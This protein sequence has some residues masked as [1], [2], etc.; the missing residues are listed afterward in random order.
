MVLLSGKESIKEFKR[1]RVDNFHQTASLRLV[2]IA[3]IHYW[4]V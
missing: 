1:D 3:V 4:V 2:L